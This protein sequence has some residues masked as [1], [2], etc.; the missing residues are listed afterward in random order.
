[1]ATAGLHTAADVLYGYGLGNT[2]TEFS[3]REKEVMQGKNYL[4]ASLTHTTQFVI[5][6]TIFNQ[7]MDALY[8]ATSWPRSIATF[9]IPILSLPFGFFA[10]AVKQG[11]YED[12]V[13]RLDEGGYRIAKY[14]PKNLSARTV[15]VLSFYA[16]HIGTFLRVAAAVSACALIY[17]GSYAIGAGIAAAFAYQQL[18]LMGV[19]PLSV[20]LFMETYAPYIANIATLLV[21]GS[22]LIRITSIF[23]LASSIP[24]INRQF[25]YKVDEFIRQYKVDE[26]I[27]QQ[28]QIAAKHVIDPFSLK[29]Y[30]GPLVNQQMN[31][32]EI[33]KVLDGRDV[34]FEVNPAH[35]SRWAI[36][37]LSLPKD[38]N[39]N[40]FLGLFEKIA[41]KENYRMIRLKLKDDEQFREVLLTQFTDL[42][43]G[44]SP[45]KNID[46]DFD[47]LIGML[48]K[49]KGQS[50]EQY[51]VERVSMQMEALVKG[52]TGEKRMVGEAAH[53]VHAQNNFSMIL[54]YVE[55]LPAGSVVKEDLLF[56]IAI[57][58]GDYCAR[59]VKR[60][61]DEILQETVIPASLS[62]GKL[63]DVSPQIIFEIKVRQA[64]QEVR[65]R[66][67]QESYH[68]IKRSLEQVSIGF[69]E[70]T[71]D[72]HGYDIYRKL[73]SLGFYPMTDSERDEVGVGDVAMWSM[74]G[75]GRGQMKTKYLYMM[76]N[77]IGGKG[78]ED[79][80]LG[81]FRFSNYI[82]NSIETN[83]KLSK[84]DK[85]AL[86]EK[87]T[88]RNANKWSVRETN[89]RLHRL[90]LVQMG[91]L[92]PRTT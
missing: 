18:D 52:L 91:I 37:N 89:S 10:A 21:G 34:D 90:M 65:H 39:F 23:M 77:I 73:L 47:E 4:I 61:S 36:E 6:A 74:F 16:E 62:S 57:A 83:Q 27:C 72:I 56:K 41:K 67:V 68:D 70:I 87:Y 1:M 59:G 75:Q 20:R 44:Q 38:R 92:R 48:A 29:D 76:D 86:L 33:D 13:K 31:R 71:K 79:N 53:V 46:R 30:E 66:L 55:S 80:G 9:V 84:E 58:A 32:A 50:V 81:E 17:F 60:A 85:E 49:E 63:K 35:C 15:R 40:K 7:A 19:V 2:Y 14:L 8:K 28:L 88:E 45:K 11:S 78:S 54:P 82:R 42:L 5:V 12:G 26:F 3:N 64:F 24:S 51:A 22:I 25:N 43:S 69:N